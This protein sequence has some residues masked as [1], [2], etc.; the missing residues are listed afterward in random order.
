MDE[1]ARLDAAAD[2]HPGEAERVGRHAGVEREG[3]VAEHASTSARFASV[4]RS[5]AS[6]RSGWVAERRER[7]QHGGVDPRRERPE[8]VAQVARDGGEDALG[9][10]IG[11][12]DHVGHGT[13]VLRSRPCHHRG[14]LA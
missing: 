10:R 2:E 4:L 8:T 3:G 6:R 5:S 9:G 11:V 1:V 12:G 7:R 13:T 14:R